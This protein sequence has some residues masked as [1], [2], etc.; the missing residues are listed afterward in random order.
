MSFSPQFLAARET[1]NKLGAAF[2]RVDDENFIDKTLRQVSQSGNP[3]DVS[4][5]M[6]QILS[7]VSPDRQPQAM[8]FLQGKLAQ[9]QAGQ[10]RAGSRALGIPEGGEYAP[11]ALQTQYLKG[12]QPKAPP[13]GLRGQ[14]IPPEVQNKIANIV[15]SN[16][17]DTAEQLSVKFAQANIP[18]TYTDS[19]IE[20]RRRQQEQKQPGSK[21]REMR[22]QSISKYVDEAFQKGEQAEETDFAIQ[23]AKK[24]VSGEIAGPGLEAIAKN[25]PYGQ[26]LLGLTTDE[27]LLQSANK[28]LLEGTKGIF[29]PKPT[30]R[31]IFLL[32]NSMLPS[33]GKSQEANLVSLGF[34]EQA[35]N[36]KR[37]HADIVSEITNGGQIYVPDVEAKVSK[38]MK[39]YI[40][41]F[42]TR[43]EEG[44]KELD[45]IDRA[46]T[47]VKVKSPSGEVGFMTQEQIDKAKADNVIFS[48]V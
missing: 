6:T 38:I 44:K 39:P 43:L 47:K 22:E 27:A 13:G 19:F 23:E 26:L 29:G 42:K 34:I 1:G 18:Q 32:L 4:N 5:A 25:N 40:E 8:Q 12:Q 30:E 10:Q 35:N 37:K 41:R 15:D 17:S 46:T 14:P 21:Y 9:L 16:P 20:T 45:R 7:Q 24:A 31:E 3:Q 11:A 36:M 48:P 33:I 2:Q 28:K